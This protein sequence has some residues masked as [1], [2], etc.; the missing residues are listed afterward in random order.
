MLIFKVR[1]NDGSKST[2]VAAANYTEE[3]SFVHFYDLSYERVAS[4]N[5][6]QVSSIVMIESLNHLNLFTG[7]EQ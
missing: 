4:F 3:G 1:T 6:M 2:K 7:E 5:K